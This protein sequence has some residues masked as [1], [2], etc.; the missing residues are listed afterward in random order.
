MG[1]EYKIDASYISPNITITAN[2]E[3]ATQHFG[4]YLLITDEV[5]TK[6]SP[7]VRTFCRKID[8]VC[9]AGHDG[10]ME[11]YCV[12]LDPAALREEPVRKKLV[13][14]ARQRYKVRQ[15]LESE[16]Y[17]T[18]NDATKASRF[19]HHD[20]AM[21]DMRRRYTEEFFQVFQ[22]GYMNYVEGEWH[23]AQEQ[24][25]RARQILGGPDGPSESLLSFMQGFMHEAPADWKGYRDLEPLLQGPLKRRTLHP[26]VT[27]QNPASD[28]YTDQAPGNET[29]SLPNRTN[30]ALHVADLPVPGDGDSQGSWHLPGSVPS[31]KVE[32][33]GGARRSEQEQAW[34]DRNT[35]T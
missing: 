23:V 2:V 14:N 1:S 18:W 25:A 3:T 4:I 26:S 5:V 24:L 8:T 9:L 29:R 27:I 12:D 31:D 11:L 28:S 15:F 19:L 30:N 33:A 32:T 10:K 21:L 7:D 34:A 22:M 16:R 13:W 17:A 35:I 6:C 20:D